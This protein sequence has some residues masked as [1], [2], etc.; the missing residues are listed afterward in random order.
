MKCPNIGK[1]NAEKRW[2]VLVV[3]DDMI[4]DM[5]SNKK[6]NTIVTELFIW[7]RKLNNSCTYITQ[8]YFNV[9]EDVRLNSAQDFV[10][11]IPD[12]GEL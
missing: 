3:F 5:N 9:T 12:R 10:M 6:L 1:Y 11:K 2:K 7:D 8:S 4:A